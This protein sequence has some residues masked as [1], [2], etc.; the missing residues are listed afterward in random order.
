MTTSGDA[1]GMYYKQREPQQQPSQ[2]KPYNEYR[3]TSTT[4]PQDDDSVGSNGSRKSN[5]S[6]ASRGSKA[7]RSSWSGNKNVRDYGTTNP[8][9]NSPNGDGDN[10]SN[11]VYEYKS[12]R[13]RSPRIKLRTRSQYKSDAPKWNG[14]LL[15]F[16]KF[17]NNIESFAYGA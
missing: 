5:K 10:S 14:T 15:D 4:R 2:W 6:M 17:K 12:G 7:S 11:M 16:P 9:I 3:R 1:G 13:I 8:F